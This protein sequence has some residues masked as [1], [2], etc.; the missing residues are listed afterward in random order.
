MPRTSIPNSRLRYPNMEPPKNGAMVDLPCGMRW[1][2]LPVPG[3]LSHINVWLIP[4]HGGWTL[5]DTGMGI[6][7]V[8]A[9]WE[10][11]LEQ[12]GDDPI[13]RIIVTHHHPDHFGQAAWLA[14]RCNVEVW[15]T[16]AEFDSA[17]GP[18]HIDPL[19]RASQ[20]RRNLE[21]NGMSIGDD[22]APFLTGKGYKR[23]IS[24]IP[25]KIRPIRDG[26]L[27]TIGDRQWRIIVTAGH[28]NGHAALYCEA[29]GRLISGDHVLPTISPNI[30]L[31]SEDSAADPLDDYLS[32]FARFRE[33]PP[34]TLVLPSHGRVFH[35]LHERLDELEAEHRAA[36]E[37][38]L[39]AC[40]SPQTAADLIP[41]LFPRKL[42]SLNTLL[43]FGETMA[44]L[45]YL[46]R[47]R[48]VAQISD[49]ATTRYLRTT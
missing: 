28:A 13:R 31:W 33:L 37:T 12:L 9:A 21:K 39:A 10:G 6:D 14:E 18:R 24:G 25:E 20:R 43:A 27:V 26:E 19:E 42:D 36:L 45:R 11:L 35:G 22:I 1:I 5:V 48:A 38:A 23:I 34:E 2:R 40:E 15:M 17:L 44:H 46:L 29:I 3:G 8:N 41:V 49:T 4:D 32:S 7:P 16:D 30:S 47:T